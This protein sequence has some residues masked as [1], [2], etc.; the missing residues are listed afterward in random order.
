[1][2]TA[3]PSMPIEWKNKEKWPKKKKKGAQS[4]EAHSL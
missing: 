4:E 2:N 3:N 1:M